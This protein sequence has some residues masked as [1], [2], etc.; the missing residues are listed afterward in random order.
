MKQYVLDANALVRHFLNT[1][2]ERIVEEL[3]IQ[4]S[5]GTIQVYISVINLGEVHYIL[6]K[7]TNEANV[8]T[9]F[10]TLRSILLFI[11]VD[12]A[13]S[14]ESAILKHHYKLG[15]ADCFAAELAMRKNAT[16]VT[17]DPE[18]ARL[19]KRLKV[20]TLPRHKNQCSSRT[21]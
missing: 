13:I 16:L 12:E 11:P 17:A 7:F 5:K 15:F 2:G 1:Q 18:F 20:L 10:N 6:S 3:L 14:I 8:K 4:A 21:T 9:Y 19:G